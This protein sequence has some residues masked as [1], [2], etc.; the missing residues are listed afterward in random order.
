M[1]R[2]TRAAAY[3]AVLAFLGTLTLP[4]AVTAADT[5]T[6]TIATVQDFAD[7][8]R[9]CTRDVWSQ[10]LTVELTA[11]LDLSGT[12]AAPVP[13]FQGTFHAMD[14]PFPDSHFRKRAPRLACF[15]L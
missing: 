11:D 10:D 4:I 9:G 15:V 1:R 2:L 7:F 12:N 6:F 13:I 14:I 3:A 8:A 5:G